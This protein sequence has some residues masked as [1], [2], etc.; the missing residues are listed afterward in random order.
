M[1][2]PSHPAFAGIYGTQVVAFENH[3]R[4]AACRL[5]GNGMSVPC[6][7]SIMIWCS[8]YC[9]PYID[10]IPMPISSAASHAIDSTLGLPALRCDA[11]TALGSLGRALCA[12]PMFAGT[13]SALRA[14]ASSTD[15]IRDLF[16]L[17]L[18]DRDLYLSACGVEVVDAEDAGNYI[19]AV[20]VG[21]NGLYG[22]RFDCIGLGSLSSAQQAA[23]AAIIDGIKLLHQRLVE[24]RGLR[25]NNG[26]SSFEEKGIAPRLDLVADAVAVPDCA[27]G[28]SPCEVI[29]GP[30]A[31]HIKIAECIFPKPPAGLNRFPW[32]YSGHRDEYVLLTVRQ[33]RAGLLRLSTSCK[34]GASVFP[35]GKRRR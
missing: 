21:L 23:H 34:G 35:G 1:G 4:N 12:H 16:P 19:D 30:L 24:G 9:S 25:A 8:S 7:G 20:I 22:F 5:I 15:R 29:D 13:F 28:C 6:V 10:S 33:L 2:I 3:S 11:W 32:F 17:P 27:G 14:S 31:E 18:I 26:W